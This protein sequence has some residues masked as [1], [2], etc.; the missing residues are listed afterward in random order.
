MIQADENQPSTSANQSNL[1]GSHSDSSSSENSDDD[2]L[3]SITKSIFC[4]VEFT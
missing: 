3:S 4:L 1:I 2:L